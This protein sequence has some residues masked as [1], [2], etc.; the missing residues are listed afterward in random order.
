MGWLARLPRTYHAHVWFSNVEVRMMEYVTRK[1]S[2]CYLS[3]H[4]N[5]GRMSERHVENPLSDC[6]RSRKEFESIKLDRYDFGPGPI[7]LMVPSEDFRFCKDRYVYEVHPGK[8]PPSAFTRIDEHVCVASPQY[9]LVQMARKLSDA[10]TIRLCMEFCGLYAIIPEND[11]G[12]VIRDCPVTTRSALM[13][14]IALI[15]GE[16]G[17]GK[18]LSLLRHVGEGSLSPMETCVYMLMCL[19]KRMGGYGLPHPLLNARI[20]LSQTERAYAQRSFVMSDMLWPDKGVAL[21]YDG[22]R[23]HASFKDRSRDSTKRNILLARG[24][25]V[26][27]MTAHEVLDVHAFD[28]TVRD[29]AAMMGHRLRAFPESWEARRSALRAEV[30]GRG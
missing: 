19:P 9:M 12:Y 11:M 28:R 7:H 16:P 14:F 1:S 25:T 6:P 22:Q 24:I 5:L 30:L 20:D 26:F 13:E 10:E 29:I 3:R 17:A 27:T 23:A 15:P 2:E 4:P 21:E 8:L 18:L